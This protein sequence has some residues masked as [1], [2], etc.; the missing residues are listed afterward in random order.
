MTQPANESAV[1]MRRMANG[2]TGEEDCLKL[3]IA[4]SSVVYD[5]PAPVVAY[6]GGDQPS[7]APSAD[8]AYSQGVV[9]VSIQVRQGILGYLSHTALSKSEK[10][11]TSGNYAL[12]DL[13]TALNWIKL[14]IRHFG[15][16]PDQVTILG[17]KQVR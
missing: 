9:F 3:D 4:T 16:D 7:L 8:L 13:I 6:I 10:P 12:N 2:I 5:Y 1:C 17:H 14:N 11:P 15:G